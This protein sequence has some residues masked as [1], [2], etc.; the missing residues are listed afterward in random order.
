MQ[1]I[2]TEDNLAY[3]F[4]KFQVANSCSV[5]NCSMS[6]LVAIIWQHWTGRLKWRQR[7]VEFCLTPSSSSR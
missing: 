7:I 6:L 1:K 3:K 4:R 5:W 2:G